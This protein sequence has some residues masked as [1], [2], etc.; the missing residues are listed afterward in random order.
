MK[1]HGRVLLPE[2]QRAGRGIKPGLP[3]P[4]SPRSHPLPF[5]KARDLIPRRRGQVAVLC[6]TGSA[7]GDAAAATAQAARTKA[8]T[9][10]ERASWSQATASVASGRSLTGRYA[11]PGL[12]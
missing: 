2:G 3:K 10:G 11:I 7:R 1:S 9:A 12:G 5:G 8:A 6:L 4:V